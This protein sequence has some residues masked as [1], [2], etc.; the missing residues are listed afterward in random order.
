MTAKR[1]LVF[2][3]V[4]PCG[5]LLAQT[6]L[7]RV[8]RKSGQKCRERSH[9]ETESKTPGYHQH[10]YYLHTLWNLPQRHMTHSTHYAWYNEGHQN[11]VLSWDHLSHQSRYQGH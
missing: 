2:S 4:V 11:C 1:P 3:Q 8:A 5:V 6:A 7:C 10:T 9:L